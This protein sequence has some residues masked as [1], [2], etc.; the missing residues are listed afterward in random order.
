[1]TSTLPVSARLA[2]WGTAWLRG[3]VSPD[4]LL[5][6][7]E[8]AGTMLATFASW[9]SAGCT[10]LALALPVEGDPLGLRGSELSLAAFDAGEAVI[11]LGT[12]WA[13]VPAEDGW[14]V[15]AGERSP[16]P[17]LGEADRGLRAALVETARRLAE[18]DVARWRPEVADLL[19]NLRHRPHLDHPAALDSR[20]VDLA[21]RALQAA[22]V[23][24]VALEDD[25]A[26]V[27]AY[28]MEQRRDALTVLDRAARRALVAG[29]S[30]DVW[31][32][33]ADARPAG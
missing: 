9:R 17:D 12:G 14:Q 25:G 15:V 13:V 3:Q 24:A 31:P 32:P 21:A 2:W 6:E 16:V 29:C 26:S 22:D 4:E 18:L 23:V 7:V 11:A 28:E 5:D 1:M 30:P 19:M 10:G 33:D 8:G 20:C 27:T